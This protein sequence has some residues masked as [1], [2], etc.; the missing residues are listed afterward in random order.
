MVFVSAHGPPARR[1]N[2]SEKHPDSIW[3]FG[4]IDDSARLT[5]ACA[6]EFTG[7]A[8]TG[9]GDEVH[10]ADRTAPWIISALHYCD[11]EGSAQLN[12]LLGVNKIG[13]PLQCILGRAGQDNSILIH[14]EMIYGDR[15][16]MSTHSKK[17]TDP[18][19]CVG[20]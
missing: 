7:R 4:S 20:Y 19:D 2:R 1:Y 3:V 11:Y 15:H 8:I 5:R 9:A 10:H 6:S 18:D 12:F 14:L 17:S 13:H 16:V